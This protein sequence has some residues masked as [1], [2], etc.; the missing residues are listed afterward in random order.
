MSI[1]TIAPQTESAPATRG[2]RNQRT[3]RWT[4]SLATL[5]SALV[6]WAVVAAVIDDN[7]APRPLEVFTRLVDV[8]A[9][10]EAASNFATT[11]AKIGAGFALAVAAGLPLGFLMGRSTF[12]NS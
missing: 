7:I 4:I 5:A 1:N 3:L 12:M 9:S 8:V 10:G 2:P 11:L 6:A